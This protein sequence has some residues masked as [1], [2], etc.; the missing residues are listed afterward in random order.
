M[1]QKSR[2]REQLS[3]ELLGL[4]EQIAHRLAHFG[5]QPVVWPPP[6]ETKFVELLTPAPRR[7]RFVPVLSGTR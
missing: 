6:D 2:R 3:K 4:C 5:D 1:H 7:P